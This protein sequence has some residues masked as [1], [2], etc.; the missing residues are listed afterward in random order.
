MVT[1][2]CSQCG[3]ERSGVRRRCYPCTTANSRSTEINEKR[4]QTLLGRK[5]SPE[6]RK[7]NS[8]SQKR[9]TDNQ[10]FNLAAHMAT[11]PH[12]FA[13]P[14][15][16]EYARED[17]RIMVKVAGKTGRANWK[18]RAHVVWEAANG[19]VPKGSI[20]HHR[21]EDCTDDRL[22][23]LQLV[24]RAEHAAIHAT[25]EKQRSAQRLAVVAR[26]RNHTY[27]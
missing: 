6:R 17:G 2:I 20:I 3:Q 10:R 22:E 26:K 9:R 16:A 19:P 15:G 27:Y 21:N 7:A 1:F 8:E 4:R 12:P 13:R 18:R 23:N 24:T 14:I 11:Q 5:H 25:P